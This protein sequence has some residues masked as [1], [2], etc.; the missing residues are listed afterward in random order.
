M[1]GERDFN[2]QDKLVV[3]S[4]HS[5]SGRIK[6]ISRKEKKYQLNFFCKKYFFSKMVL[7]LN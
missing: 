7:F 4:S 6:K 1:G 2:A 3:L 5:R